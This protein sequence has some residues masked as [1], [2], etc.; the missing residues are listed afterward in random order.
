[1]TAAADKDDAVNKLAAAFGAELT[2][3]DHIRLANA[4]YPRAE[5]DTEALATFWKAKVFG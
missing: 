2:P 1:M 4:E 5:T 3:K